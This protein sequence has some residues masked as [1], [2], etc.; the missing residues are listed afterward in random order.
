[1][2]EEAIIKGAGEVAISARSAMKTQ[3]MTREWPMGTQDGQSG[4]EGRGLLS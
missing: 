4:P 2:R 3:N 1:M